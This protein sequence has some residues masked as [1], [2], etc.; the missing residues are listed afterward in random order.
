MNSS[1]DIFCGV[2]FAFFVGVCGGFGNRAFRE[3]STLP[4]RSSFPRYLTSTLSP[5]F[6]S[7]SFGL[8]T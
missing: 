6:I 1:G 4:V 5:T 8:K 2:P 7:N 3:I